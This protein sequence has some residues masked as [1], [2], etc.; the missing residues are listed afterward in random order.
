MSARILS[1][2][3][4]AEEVRAEAV[5]MVGEVAE[6]GGK[7][8]LTA[9]MVGQPPAAK[10]YA[11]GQAKQCEQVG[12]DYGLCELPADITVDQLRA[13]IGKLNADPQVTG[14]MVHLPLPEGMDPAAIQL[15]IDPVKDVEGVH[16]V[17]LGK[18][19]YEEPVIAP[20]TALAAIALVRNSG[21]ELY[22]AEVVMVGHSNIVGKPI[23][24][25]LVAEFAT[26]T[27]CHIGTKDLA[28]HTRQADILIVAVGK[29]GLIT[30]DMVKAGAVVIDV[31]INRIA[32]KDADGKSRTTM[33]GD[34]D[35]EAVQEVA[36]AISPVPG[37]VGVVTTAML[38]RN[39]AHAARLQM[40]AR[41]SGC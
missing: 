36:G 10:A 33:V 9:V 38:L 37:G 6:A 8:R 34:V 16:P 35:F 5:R 40:S 17:N 41:R 11:R 1:G 7:V 4:V 28:N 18:I 25:L 30:A 24:L 13:E 29:P 21:A 15:E 31:G 39:T 20:C 32:K 12:I 19:F 2:K 23:A 27:I 3:E 14:V 26:T 22:G